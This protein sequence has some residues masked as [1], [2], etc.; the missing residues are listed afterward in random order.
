LILA[1]RHPERYRKVMAAA[2]REALPLTLLETAEFGASHPEIAAY[3]FGTWGLPTVIVEAVAFHHDPSAA[4]RSAF[5]VTGAVHVAEVLANEVTRPTNDASGNRSTL[6]G[7][8]LETTGVSGQLPGW[9]ALA[10]SFVKAQ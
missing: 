6:D 5:D 2:A 9:R 7:A 3:L 8:Y 4:G 10:T 1:G